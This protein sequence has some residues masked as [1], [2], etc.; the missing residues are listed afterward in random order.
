MGARN[1]STIRPIALKINLSFVAINSSPLKDQFAPAGLSSLPT[2]SF[3]KIF[4]L[5]FPVFKIVKHGA[6]LNGLVQN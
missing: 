1:T 4:G 3:V 6:R 5:V 2:M